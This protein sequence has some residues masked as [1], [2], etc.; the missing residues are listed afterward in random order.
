MTL[1]AIFLAFPIQAYTDG[2]PNGVP[3]VPI[4]EKTEQLYPNLGSRLNQLVTSVEAAQEKDADDTPVQA[5]AVAVTIY[6]SGETD[7]LVAFLEDNDVGRIAP[8]RWGGLRRSL[9]PG[10]AP[11]NS[12]GNPDSLQAA[13]FSTSII[14]V[15]VGS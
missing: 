5:E 9:R 10:D 3:P 1:L 14:D 12:D 8:E 6:L 4:P 2:D 11:R 13:V 7:E 15:I